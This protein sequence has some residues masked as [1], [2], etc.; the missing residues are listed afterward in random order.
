MATDRRRERKGI[1]RRCKGDGE[2]DG[3]EGRKLEYGK[4][5]NSQE[6]QRRADKVICKLYLSRL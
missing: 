3:E 4:R 6:R 1:A 5:K 2:M